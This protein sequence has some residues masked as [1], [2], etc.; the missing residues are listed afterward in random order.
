MRAD[1]VPSIPMTVH[2]IDGGGV[3]ARPGLRPGDRCDAEAR[4][5]AR[6]VVYVQLAGDPATALTLC[7]HHWDEHAAAIL[8]RDPFAVCDGRLTEEGS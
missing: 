4:H 7:G 8:R 2:G 6:A 5:P 1:A 3:N